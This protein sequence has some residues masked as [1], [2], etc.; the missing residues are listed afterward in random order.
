M[1]HAISTGGKKAKAA[2]PEELKLISTAAKHGR[3]SYPQ[4]VKSDRTVILRPGTGWSGG[5]VFEWANE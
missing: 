2:A 1:R 3:P 5:Q 4:R